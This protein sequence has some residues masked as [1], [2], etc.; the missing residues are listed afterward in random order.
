MNLPRLTI[1]VRSGSEAAH[2]K[3]G[4]VNM[5]ARPSAA[6]QV[7]LTKVVLF[8]GAAPVNASPGNSVGSRLF[9]KTVCE[10]NRSSIVPAALVHNTSVT[11]CCVEV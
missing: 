4:C 1:D 3:P 10:V 5:P 2:R 7:A 9:T 6:G 8:V 11:N